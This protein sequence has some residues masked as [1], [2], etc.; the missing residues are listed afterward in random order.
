MSRQT[1]LIP[2]IL[3]VK[4]FEVGIREIVCISYSVKHKL[5]G[6]KESHVTLTIHD[7]T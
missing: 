5:K 2:V 1:M 7:D 6:P 4:Y 3:Y